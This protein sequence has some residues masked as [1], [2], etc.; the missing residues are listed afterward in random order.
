MT[1]LS[2]IQTTLEDI[3][4]NSF[5]FEEKNFL[6]RI[7]TIDF[8]EFQISVA[9]EKLQMEKALIEKLAHLKYRTENT[10]AALEKINDRLFQKLQE[11]IKFSKN[12]DAH[13]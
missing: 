13:G 5:L 8:L 3:E 6:K 9:L 7:E 10:M 2:E 11:N 12:R 4:N 1:R